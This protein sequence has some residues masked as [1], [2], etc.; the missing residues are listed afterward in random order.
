MGQRCLPACLLTVDCCS[1][2]ENINVVLL[3][4]LGMMIARGWYR[5][6]F[7]NRLTVG[8]THAAVQ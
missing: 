6:I 7:I 8:H 4:T 1:G 3:A 2:S 5:E